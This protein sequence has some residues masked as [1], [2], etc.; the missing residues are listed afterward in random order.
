V[1]AL[2]VMLT[3]FPSARV[4]GASL[5]AS[6]GVAGLVI[7]VAGRSII[8]NLLAGVQILFSEPIRLD[9]VVVVK[10][11]WGRVE[12]ITFTYVIVRI[13]DDRRLS[14]P[15]SYFIDTPF[16]NWT[17]TGAS[18]LATVLMQVD[19][20]VPVAAVREELERILQRSKLWDGRTWNLQVTDIAQGMVQLR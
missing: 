20:L 5:L 6:A 1:L 16:E 14:L 7:G 9:D 15:V 18:L 11:E 19:F 3:T 8:G 4:L 17:H 13:W 10:G 12:E 2:A